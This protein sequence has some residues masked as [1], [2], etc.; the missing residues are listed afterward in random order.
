[1][2]GIMGMVEMPNRLAQNL[3]RFIRQNN[4]AL[5][6]KRR[7]KEFSALTDDE[8]QSLEGIVQDAFE[9][10]DDPNQWSWTR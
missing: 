8:V 6:K 3:I 4:G 7:E 1:M 9:G 2:T 5:S 10:F